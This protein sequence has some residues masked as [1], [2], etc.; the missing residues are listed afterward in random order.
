[1]TGNLNPA[2]RRMGKSNNITDDG[3]IKALKDENFWQGG[4]TRHH[5][6]YDVHGFSPMKEK[7]QAYKKKTI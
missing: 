5:V 1:M 2:F 4:E 6:Q 3:F 7:A